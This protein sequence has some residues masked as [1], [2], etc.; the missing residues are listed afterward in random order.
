[1]LGIWHEGDWMKERFSSAQSM[2]GWYVKVPDLVGF[3]YG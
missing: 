1:M 3:A 2:V